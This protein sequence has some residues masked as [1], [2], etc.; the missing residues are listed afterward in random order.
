MVAGFSSALFSVFNSKMV[1]RIPA[2]TITFYE[3]IGACLLIGLFL[4]VYQV[5]WAENHQLQ[6]VPQPTDWLY[7]AI[8]AGV[9]SVYA[10]SV[11][12]ELMK[13]IS[14]F[15]LQLSL[16][17]EPIYGMIMANIIFKDKEKMGLNFYLGAG[18][19]VSAVLLYPLIKRR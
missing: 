16:N 12:V 4:P 7:I 8:L 9:C 6:M 11:G 14:V 19:I 3:M 17:L 5:T 2:Y 10:Y 13:K 15:M 1:Q 18:I